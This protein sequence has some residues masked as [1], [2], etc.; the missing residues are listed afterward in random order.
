[1]YL[2]EITPFFIRA[3]L[4]VVSTH[5]ILLLR[6]QKLDYQMMI[7]GKHIFIANYFISIYVVEN[8]V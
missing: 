7:G 4:V 5:H 2:V 3:L 8:L 6:V 1:M